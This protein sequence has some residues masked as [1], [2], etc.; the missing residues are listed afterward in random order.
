M[1]KS[2]KFKTMI[3]LYQVFAVIRDK[4]FLPPVKLFSFIGITANMLSYFSVVL[5]GLFIVFIRKHNSISLILLLTSL[6]IDLF[7]GVLARYQGTASDRGK[8]V[9]VIC[10][11]VNFSLFLI[12]LLHARLL[13]GMI[14]LILVYLMVMSKILR[15]IKNGL[16]LKSDWHFKAIAGFLPNC[17]VGLSYLVFLIYVIKPHD[18][19]DITFCFFSGVLFVDSLSFFVRIVYAKKKSGN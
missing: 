4:I 6:T 2:P 8:F 17:V 16:A 11:N 12:G 19:F 1:E 18:Y 5:M 15:I 14:G 13:T 3:S 7:D 10:D 9:D